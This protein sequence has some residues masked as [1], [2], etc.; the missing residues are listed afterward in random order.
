MPVICVKSNKCVHENAGRIA[1]MR[2]PV[3]YCAEGVDNGED[4]AGIAVSI[5]SEFK[6]E[7]NDF[8]LPS[9]STCAYREKDSDMLYSKA[10]D[11]Y[12]KFTLRLIPYYAF[13]N[14]GETEMVVWF[15]RK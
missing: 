9:L 11:D 4:L 6:L 2:G 3:L 8:I 5:S 7:D 15:L 14:R 12:E 13:A 10:G 1:I